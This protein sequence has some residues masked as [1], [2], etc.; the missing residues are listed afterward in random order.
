[1]TVRIA[2]QSDT[3]RGIHKDLWVE[4]WRKSGELDGRRWEAEHNRWVLRIC[5]VLDKAFTRLEKEN[6]VSPLTR[7]RLP[8]GGKR[9]SRRTLEW[10]FGEWAKETREW[11]CQKK[12]LNQEYRK[13][14]EDTT[15]RR[16]RSTRFSEFL[17]L[18]FKSGS[19]L[20]TSPGPWM[21]ASDR[22]GPVE[23][24]SVLHQAPEQRREFWK[25]AM[26][27]HKRGS[28]SRQN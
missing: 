21:K 28:K 20:P 17:R 9:L 13:R 27:R 14:W 4:C 26:G 15:R 23:S 6:A 19:N 1:M 25:Q 12:I 5:E 24:D 8:V 2:E 10:P 16:G 18:M 11:V 3:V 7:M 22:Y